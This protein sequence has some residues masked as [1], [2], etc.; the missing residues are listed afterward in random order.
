MR[1]EGRMSFA[2]KSLPGWDV[3]GVDDVGPRLMIRVR[4]PETEHSCPRCGAG[5]DALL[6]HGS[7]E[8]QFVEAP[9]SG[10]RTS[11]MVK[12]RRHVCAACQ[13]VIAQPL[14]LTIE[15]HRITVRC[16]DQILEQ[17]EALPLLQVAEQMGVHRMVVQ[18][19]AGVGR[20]GAGRPRA[21]ETAHLEECQFCRRRVPPSELERHHV[22]VV[23][24][25][26]AAPPPLL[27][28]RECN[29]LGC[30]D[31]VCLDDGRP[32]AAEECAAAGSAKVDRRNEV[33]R[34][35]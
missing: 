4:A 14:P 22:P 29:R 25:S 24:W 12:R 7:R 15:E 28:C 32:G 33:A 17:A 13:A 6:G 1:Y 30:H 2:L 18:R 16:R 9:I 27:L 8:Q 23:A 3:L 35:K 20:K 5:N 31:W 26:D 19:I 11:L 34:N 10:R 21:D